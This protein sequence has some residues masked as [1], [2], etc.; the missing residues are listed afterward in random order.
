MEAHHERAIVRAFFVPGERARYLNLLSTARGRKKF[1]SGLSHLDALGSRFVRRLGPWE[2]D[3]D[4]IES[5]L[6]ERGAPTLCYLVSENPRLDLQRM[7]LH[8]ALRATV[9][10]GMDTFLSRITGQLAY[11]EGEEPGS[12]YICEREN[13]AG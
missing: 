9:G 10:S 12:R 5:L 4:G 2:Q 3:V 7:K 11:F 1:V 6:K 13:P 8:D